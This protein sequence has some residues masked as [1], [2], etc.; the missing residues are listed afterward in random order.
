MAAEVTTRKL[1]A[2]D[3]AAH[4][5]VSVGTVS[6]VV[7]GVPS[8]KPEVRKRVQQAIAALDWQPN[9]VAQNMRGRTSRMIG[10]VFSDV[11]NPLYASMIKG[12]EDVLSR[13][14]YMLVV[15]SSDG[16]PDREAAFIDLFR[17]RQ[18]EG[19][20]FSIAQEKHPDVLSALN[21]ARFPF[22]LLEREIS[23]AVD[24]V[25]ADHMGGVHHA[26]RYLL[27]LGHRRIAMISGGAD[28]RVGR[29]RISAFFAAYAEAGLTP[30]AT[31][32][33]RDSFSE[34][35][36]FHQAEQLLD[37]PEPPTAIVVLGQHLLRGVL[38]TVRRKGVS[39]PQQLSLIVSNDS[40]LARF[41]T[42]AI[43]AIRYDSYAL[44]R[45]AALLLLRRLKEGPGAAAGRITV[46]TEF[47]LRDSCAA[48]AR[49]HEPVVPAD[50]PA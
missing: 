24:T 6:R 34:E 10:F 15:A 42:P 26:T 41:V 19:L 43:S 46:P 25:G 7:N 14:G 44:G 28:N 18:A 31:L 16:R 35:Y 40:E 4:A 32:I 47:I 39:I 21:S 23:P 11:R 5:G 3:V 17:Q 36:G 20:I 38:S 49:V 8:V 13:A 12:A 30:D 27:G 50:L 2:R 1:T 37:L 22:V 29:E 9:I 33:R 48:P 45:E